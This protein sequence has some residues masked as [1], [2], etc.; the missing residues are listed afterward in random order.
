MGLVALGITLVA[1]DTGLTAPGFD[2]ELAAPGTALANFGIDTQTGIELVAL[3]IA[4][5][6]QVGME[7]FPLFSALAELRL[8]PHCL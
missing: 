7:T 1:L 6:T 2:S 5:G 8:V 4:F 3:G